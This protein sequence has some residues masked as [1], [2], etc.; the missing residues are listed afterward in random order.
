MFWMWLSHSLQVLFH[1]GIGSALPMLWILDTLQ[2]FQKQLL[3]S[4]R[5]HELFDAA[6]KSVRRF[7]LR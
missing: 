7:Y 5:G 2:F 1:P 6:L 4:F 3:A